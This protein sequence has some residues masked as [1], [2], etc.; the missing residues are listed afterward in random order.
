MD[1]R[2]LPLTE[3]EQK[4]AAALRLDLSKISH[5]VDLVGFF[6]EHRSFPPSYNLG[7]DSLAKNLHKTLTK[8]KKSELDIIV[9]QIGLAGPQAVLNLTQSLLYEN[10]IANSGLE[11]DILIILPITRQIIGIILIS[12]RLISDN[13]QYLLL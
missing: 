7:E 3:E 8:L 10:V 12:Y 13:S 4:C 11:M 9:D 2:L 1:Y 6:I 5:Y